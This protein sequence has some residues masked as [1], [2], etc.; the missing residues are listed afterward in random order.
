VP[1]GIQSL[2]S[3]E[4]HDGTDWATVTA[5]D[6]VSR[7]RAYEPRIDPNQP[8]TMLMFKDDVSGSLSSFPTGY[9][10]IRI[11]GTLGWPEPPAKL[12]EIADTMVIRMYQA[13]QTGQR[14]FVGND[15]EGNP[16]ISRFLSGEDKRVLA[17]F[18]YQIT[19]PAVA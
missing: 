4:T 19:P 13:R 16:I 2:T 1:F 17:T 18:R 15:E 12:G 6:L 9:E 8:T 10:D 7:P 11:T 3:V 5:T 14:D